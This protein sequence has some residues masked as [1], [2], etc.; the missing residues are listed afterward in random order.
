MNSHPADQPDPAQLSTALIIWTGFGQTPR[1]QRDEERLARHIGT[2]ATIK[3]MPQL[4]KLEDDFYATSA[5]QTAPDL[6]AMGRQASEDFRRH[7]PEISAEAVN[8]LA[9]CYTWDHK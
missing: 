4:R 5:R 2:H 7:H 6:P 8:A 3:L 1:P 9:W